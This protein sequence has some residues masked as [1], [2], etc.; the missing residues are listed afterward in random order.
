RLRAA[1][2][3]LHACTGNLLAA[4]V[5]V[6]PQ[7]AGAARVRTAVGTHD[8]EDGFRSGTRCRAGEHRP[9]AARGLRRQSSFGAGHPGAPRDRTWAVSHHGEEGAL[10]LSVSRLAPEA[11]G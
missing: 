9:G 5:T 3:S 10:P 11:V 7:R 8:P 6:R 2:L 1:G 4:V